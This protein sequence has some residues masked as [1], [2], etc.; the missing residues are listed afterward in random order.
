MLRE[1]EIFVPDSVKSHGLPPDCA[2]DCFFGRVVELDPDAENKQVDSESCM[3]PGTCR[4][5]SML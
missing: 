1:A 4:C 3:Q 2:V 5:S